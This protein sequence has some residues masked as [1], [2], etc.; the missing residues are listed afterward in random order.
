MR[1]VWLVQ[2]NIPRDFSPRLPHFMGRT[3]SAEPPAWHY[4][5]GVEVAP[6]RMASLRE[7]CPAHE[8]LANAT[9]AEAKS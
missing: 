1:L 7:L 5:G 4:V 2:L 6:E 9:W 8:G 3:H